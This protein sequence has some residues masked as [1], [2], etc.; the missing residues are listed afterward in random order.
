MASLKK[1]V[2]ETAIYGMST[3]VGRLLNYFLIPLHTRIF[4]PGEYGMVTELYS[5]VA[6]F[7]VLLTYGMETAFFRFCQKHETP[8]VFSTAFNSVAF[9][10][11]IFFVSIWVFAQPIA[12]SLHYDS[13]ADYIILFAAILSLDAI[14]SIPFA[15]LRQQKRP[16]KFAIIKNLNIGLTIVLN[17]YFLLFCPWL[18]RHH[19]SHWLL[20]TYNPALGVS[21]VFYINFV[22][23]LIT[24]PLLW[25]EIAGCRN[26]FHTSMWKE[27]LRYAFP[28]LIVGLAGMIN[29][30]FSRVMF[31]Y[32]MPG[33]TDVMAEL[34]IFGAN[35]RFAVLMNLFIQAFRYAA[36][37]FFFAQSK[38]Q[39][40][41]QTY[42]RVTHYFSI[43]CLF[44]FLLVTLFI[45]Q[46]KIF[47]GEKFHEG[48]VIVPILLLANMFLGIYY[49]LSI[50]YKLSDKTKYGAYISL[51]GAVLTIILNV[52]LIPAYGYY[53]AAWVSFIT[54]FSIM[55]ISYWQG[56][57]NYPVPYK[58]G[59]FFMYTGF[60]LLLFFLN[61]YIS[62][63][64]S[65]TFASVAFQAALL[66][67]FAGVIYYIEKKNNF[68]R[69]LKEE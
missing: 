12:G 31:K 39:D 30:T 57:K 68:G 65:T 19:P 33:N 53:G 25:K 28:I 48:L 66:M 4:S 5:Y 60:A 32:L 38:N 14:T 20:S 49:N 44:I 6:F 67:L 51:T 17:L 58:V 35:I 55:A 9:S 43:A 64:L 15:L 37:P 40:R 23:S 11:V 7:T 63:S 50:W 56:Q 61:R 59:T 36:E 10:S 45:N 42:A 18:Q 1:L 8:K 62:P 52:L 16:I 54:Y 27:Q 26:G 41:Q 2:S 47:I 69:I 13:H 46:F 21:Y 3:I 22:A 24:L 29:E 34:G